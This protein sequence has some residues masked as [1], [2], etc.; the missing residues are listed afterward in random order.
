MSEKRF[1][2]Y[3]DQKKFKASLDEETARYQN[4]PYNNRVWY[5]MKYIKNLKEENNE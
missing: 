4:C 5:W 2:W 3:S 1:P